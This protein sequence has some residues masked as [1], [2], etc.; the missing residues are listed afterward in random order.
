[1]AAYRLAHLTLRSADNDADMLQ[2]ADRL[3]VEASAENMLGATPY[4]YR[5]AT[6]SR[7]RSLL[8]EGHERSGVQQ[9]MDE[10]FQEAVQQLRIAGHGTA[11]PEV[12]RRELNTS[13]FNLLELCCYMLGLPY[14]DL[15]GMS[16]KDADD[17]LRAKGRWHLV[18]RGIHRIMMNE[19]LARSEFQARG[20]AAP[21]VMIELSQRFSRWGLSTRDADSLKDLNEDHARFFLVPLETP[22]L[23]PEKFLRRV[24]G[25]DGPD[26]QGRFRQTKRRAKAGFKRLTGQEYNEAPTSEGSL[27]ILGLAEGALLSRR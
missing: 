23:S 17:P 26:P 21:C 16:L 22:S 9:A 10:V 19:R 13:A 6:L 11:K 4:I 8:P 18:G 24:A 14:K 5:L 25:A 7:R 27:P 20:A 1:V 15:E 2:A 12:E 3:F